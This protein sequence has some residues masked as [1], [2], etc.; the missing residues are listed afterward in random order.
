MGRSVE[1]AMRMLMNNLDPEVA[2]R[3]QDLVVYGGTGRAARSWEAFDAIVRELR[4]LKGDETLLVQSGKPVGVFDTHEWAP[5][6][7]ISN[8]MLVPE[9]A[10]WDEFRR[11]EALGLTMYGQMTAGSWIYIGTQGI[12][13]GTY[14]T[15]AAVARKRFGGSLAGT[16]TLTAGLGGMGGAPRLASP[17]NGGVALCVEVE[18]AR[19]ARRV[20]H[21]CLVVGAENHDDGLRLAYEAR[22]ARRALSI[23][24]PGNA[25]DVFPELARRDFPIDV[26]TDQTPAPDPL[27]YVPAGLSPEDAAELRLDEP[28]VYVK[29]A[30]ESM[31][32]Q[33]DAMVMLQDRGAEVFDYGNSLRAEARLGGSTRAFEYPGF[34]PAYIRPLFSEGKGPFRWVALSGDPAD[35]AATD[36]AMVDEFSDDPALVRWIK[37]AGERVSYQGLPARICWLGYGERA[38]AGR[39][40]N[41]LVRKGEVGAPIV[42]GR[43]HLDSG[44]VAS[45][46][47]ETEA[48]QDGSDAIALQGWTIPGL[49]NVH[50]HA[51]QRLLRGEIESGGGDFW[52]WRAQMYR[53]TEWDPADYFKHAQLVFREMLEAGITAVGEFHYLHSHGNGLGE[54]LID[55]AHEEGIRITLIDACYLR[56][57][58]DGRPLE[59]EQLT[60]SDGDADSWALRMDQMK[61]T[62]DARLAAAIHSVPAATS[63]SMRIVATYARERRMPL[64]VHLA[65]QPAEV[66]ECLAVE[67]CTPAELLEREGILGPDLTAVHAIHASEH[68]IPL[69]GENEAP[70]CAC[71]PPD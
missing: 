18:E 42:I 47:R 38:R 60:F 28:D 37:A 23:G 2:E 49:A 20:E 27:S 13:Q 33:V 36:R 31:A 24:V 55:A 35:I 3:P 43:D 39:R 8:S 21:R 9:W 58:L 62:D 59:A 48:M 46:Y 66:E 17:L 30:R 71:P 22:R 44:S 65:E 15:F 50:S 56:G 64:H 1:A 4:R 5:R 69:L 68:D 52:E 40:F 11:L 53:F 7:L 57:G 14:E 70:I 61:D 63:E 34:V 41:E 16:I 12:L 45:P 67:G 32:R 54:A 6:V 10:T 19:I 25:A 29:R 51:L 26:V